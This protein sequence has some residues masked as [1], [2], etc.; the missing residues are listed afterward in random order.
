MA[1]QSEPVTVG[2]VAIG[3][4]I[5][6]ALRWIVGT[7][8]DL[9][10]AAAFPWHT[11]AVNVVG[12]LAIGAAS[13]RLDPDGLAW[14]FGSTGVLGGFTTMSAFAVELND[15]ADADRTGVLVTYLVATV[16]AGVGAVVIGER[17]ARRRSS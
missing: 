12:C 1:N 9:G 11:L 2:A 10:D 13:A 5:G 17:V 8:L 4:L 16:A 7:Q 14:A 15:L 6:A 3:G